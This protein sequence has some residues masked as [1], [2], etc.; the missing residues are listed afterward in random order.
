MKKRENLEAIVRLL[1]KW[2]VMYGEPYVVAHI[3][4]GYGSA[5]VVPDRPDHEAIQIS[6]NFEES[7]A[8]GAT[9]E[10]KNK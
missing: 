6:V 4:N 7:Q 3:Y 1:H 5:G 8:V 2:S 10:S 9:R